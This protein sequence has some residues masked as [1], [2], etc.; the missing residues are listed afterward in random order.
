MA[1]RSTAGFPEL[2]EDLELFSSLFG[3]IQ[4]KALSCSPFTVV[5]LLEVRG[6][7]AGGNRFYLE[8]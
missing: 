1:C 4:L 5:R 7:A 6:F 2:R 8:L 3:S